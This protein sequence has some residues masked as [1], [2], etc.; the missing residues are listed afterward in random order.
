MPAPLLG[1]RNI[2]T[3]R[4]CGYFTIRYTVNCGKGVMYL[5]TREIGD[6]GNI[7]KETKP[8]FR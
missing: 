7:Q 4:L 1:Y 6:I 8:Y 3:K 2:R 5:N